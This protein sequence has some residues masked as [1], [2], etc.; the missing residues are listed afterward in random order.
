MTGD[1]Q[2]EAPVVCANS[3]PPATPSQPTL[4][5]QALSQ[6]SAQHDELIQLLPQ[7][8]AQPWLKQVLLENQQAMQLLLQCDAS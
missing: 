6:L 4:L 1:Q 3:V 5:Q 7:Y 2:P 8:G